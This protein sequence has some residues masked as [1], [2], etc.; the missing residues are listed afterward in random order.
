MSQNEPKRC[1]SDMGRYRDTGTVDNIRRSGRS[2]AIT[3]VYDCYLRI[4]AR[5]NPESNVTML[6]N[7]FHAATGCRVSTQTVRNRLHDV[8]CHSRRPW[9]GLHLTPRNHGVRYRWA[10]K[11]AEWTRQNWQ[12]VLFTDQCRICL[13]PDNRRR[14]VWRQS[15]W[16]ERLRH[17]VQRVQQCD[18]SLIFWGGIMWGRRTPLV[19]MV[20]FETAIQYTNDILRSIVQPLRHTFGE[21]FVLMDD[22]NSHPHRA[23]LVNEFLHDNNITRVA[24]MFSRHEPY[25]T[26]LEFSEK[27]CF[28]TR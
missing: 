14:R 19:I 21:D 13:Q 2:K 10:Q 17:T 25:R 26:C 20:G 28:W 15:G 16:A 3:A 5:R 7:A 23:Y 12:Q 9:R 22:N 6:N 27:G 1:C 4:L 18:G 8:Q 24:S 11:H